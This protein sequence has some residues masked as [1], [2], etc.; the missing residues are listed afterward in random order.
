MSAA[1][2]PVTRVPSSTGSWPSQGGTV[3]RWPTSA[4]ASSRSPDA[5]DER[6]AEALERDVR[7][8]AAARLDEVG[9]RGLVTGH[10]RDGDE[11]ERE[12]RE[13]LGVG[14]QRISSSRRSAL[15]SGPALAR[16]LDGPGNPTCPR[17]LSPRV[18]PGAE[19]DLGRRLGERRAPVEVA[20]RSAR[21][22]GSARP[23][24]T[25]RCR[26]RAAPRTSSTA[27]PASIPASAR[28]DARAQLVPRPR[29]RRRRPPAGASPRPTGGRARARGSRPA[30]RARAPRTT[31]RRSFACR[32]AA[33][34]GSRSASSA[35]R[36][37]AAELVVER[38]PSAPAAPAAPP[39]A[40]RD[41]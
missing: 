15:R 4:T 30:R 14:R 2:R 29:A 18:L 8:R 39:A 40:A 38:R 1:P 9:E 24:R 3:S 25:A 5:H 16:E 31:R 22:R 33:A 32:R 28:G 35:E 20:R 17:L 21:G 19:R 27:P 23:S 11:L 34:R 13:C 10:A 12:P 6:V 37:G 26:S 36:P 41:R 7:E